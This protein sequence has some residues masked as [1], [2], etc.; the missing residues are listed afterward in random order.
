MAN[1][2]FDSTSELATLTNTFTVNGVATDPTTVSL[3]VTDPTGVSLTYTYAGAQITKSS[4]GKYTKD[5]QCSV[6]GEWSYQWIGTGSASDVVADSFTVFSSNLARLYGTPAALKTRLGISDNVDDFQLLVACEAASRA[7]EVYCQR[8]FYRT[9]AS[10]VRTF[11]PGTTNYF[12]LPEFCDLVSVDTF[13]T[14][15]LADGSYAT[16]W[17]STDYVLLAEGHDYNAGA[18][19]EQLPYVAIKTINNR[20]FTFNYL[21]ENSLQIAGVWGWPVV[22]TAVREGALI[23][24]AELFKL[25]DAPAG[26]VA[27]LG[28]FG[29]VTIRQNPQIRWLVDGYRRTEAA[30]RV[31]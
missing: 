23:L 24:A 9:P 14:D 13:K 18:A 4:T 11:K 16:T 3:V 10:T 2:F 1:V 20:L 5:I 12:R 22:P 29:V 6:A 15:S 21:R 31:G 27:G 28:D 7:T 8:H 30:V 26:G 17:A 25:K 19:P